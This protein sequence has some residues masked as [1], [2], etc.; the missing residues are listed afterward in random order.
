MKHADVIK[1][2]KKHGKFPP[3]RQRCMDCRCTGKGECA[4]ETIQQ[5]NAWQSIMDNEM[6]GK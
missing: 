4:G 5:Q 2:I 1:Y 3:G 6:R